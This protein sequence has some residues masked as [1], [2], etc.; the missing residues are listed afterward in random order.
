MYP[1]SRPTRTAWPDG[2]A[3]SPGVEGPADLPY[4]EAVSAINTYIDQDNPLGKDFDRPRRQGRRLVHAAR[5]RADH[6]GRTARSR[7]SSAA[8]TCI[9]DFFLPNFRVK[10]DAVPGHAREDRTSRRTMTSARA[11][12]RSAK[13]YTL[14]EL[15]E[16]ACK[17]AA[18]RRSVDRHRRDSPG[19]E[20]RTNDRRASTTADTKRLDEG[21]QHDRPRRPQPLADEADKLAR[22]AAR[23]AG[24]T[25]VH[26]VRAGLLG[27]GL[28]RTL[29]RRATT[30]M[31]RRAGRRRRTT[32]TTTAEAR[33]ARR[34]PRRPRRRRGQPTSPSPST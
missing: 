7:C 22:T 24:V 18:Q 3:S 19:A 2:D 16:V 5:P 26:G 6:P 31:Q 17:P 23:R 20:A 25:E 15:A 14:D 11:W 9:H 1:A 8:R 34:R 27:A 32:S 21:Q 30:T 13:T 10:L 33:Q 29:R 4:D 12:S 28:R